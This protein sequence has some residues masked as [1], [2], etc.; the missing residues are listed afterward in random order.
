[1]EKFIKE[2]SNI[3]RIKVPFENLYT[4]VFLITTDTANVLVDCATYDSDVDGFIVPALTE[5]GIP[6]K[7]LKFLVLTHSHGDHVGGKERLIALNPNVRII[8]RLLG[9]NDDLEIYSLPGHTLDCVGVLDKRSGTLI[10]GDGIQGDGIGKYRRSL[11]S[12]EAYIGVLNKI[13]N[14]KRIKNILFSHAYEPWGKDG[15]FGVREK[16]KIINYCIENI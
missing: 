2:T 3:Y 9:V 15:V 16:E 4:S 10:S 1:M 8:D 7:S 11:E 13:K 5:M 6:I 14:D 12:K